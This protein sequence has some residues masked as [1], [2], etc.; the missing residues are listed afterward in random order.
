[1]P[2]LIEALRTATQALAAAR[3]PD[4]EV[5][6]RMLICAAA[7]IDRVTLIRDPELPLA[8]A[9]AVR[10]DAWICRR[11]RREPV[12]RILGCRDFWGLT[13]RV[14]PD[15]LDPRPDTETLVEAVLDGLGARRAE[16]LRLLDLGTGSGAIL[17]ALLTE[18][19]RASGWAVDRSAAACRIARDNLARCGMSGRSL[20]VQGHWASA[21]AAHVVD[22]V[23]SNPPYVET[24]LIPRLAIDVREYDPVAALDGGPDGLAAHRALA[25]DLPRLLARGGFA[26]FEVGRGQDRDVAEFMAAVGLSAIATRRD[27]SGIGRVVTGWR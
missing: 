21:M 24:A 12:S 10:L 17:C 5:D 11:Q 18:L 23:V 1:M 20:V 14:T 4:P 7:G 25:V 3:V 13:V 9:D 19:P 16:P 22:V 27:L 15:V 2:S 8:P 26:A 6:A